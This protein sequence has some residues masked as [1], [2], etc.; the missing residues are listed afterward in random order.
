MR[1]LATRLINKNG[2][3]IRLKKVGAAAP[4]DPTPLEPWDPEGDQAILPAVPNT[5]KTPPSTNPNPLLKGVVIPVTRDRVDDTLVRVNDQMC[6]ISAADIGSI[7]ITTRDRIIDRNREF[8][9][10][11]VTDISPG[12]QKVLY[13]LQLRG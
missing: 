5:D 12:D 6:Y 9:I 2:R 3:T 7:E 8:T 13:M 10:V 11:E 4:Q 1:A